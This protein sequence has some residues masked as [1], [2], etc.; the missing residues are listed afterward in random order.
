MLGPRTGIFLQHSAD[1][2]SLKIF[3][4]KIAPSQSV[5]PAQQHPH[6]TMQSCASRGSFGDMF[7]APCS[8]VVIY[9]GC[10]SHWVGSEG[11]PELQCC[12]TFPPSATEDFVHF[13]RTTII[14]HE[15][16]KY[17]PSLGI[18]HL[19]GGKPPHPKPK[20]RPFP[21]LIF[22]PYLHSEPSSQTLYI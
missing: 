17:T 19:L 5:L 22:F 13:Y 21:C 10:V 20:L 9:F 12:F 11:T 7:F 14:N 6:R 8:S 18:P 4:L 16:F 2:S 1:N 3:G 15:V